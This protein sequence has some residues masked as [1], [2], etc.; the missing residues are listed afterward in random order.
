MSIDKAQEMANSKSLDLVKIAPQADPPVCR[1]MDYGKYMFEL[2][3]KDK[4]ARKKQK[5]IGTKEIRLTPSIEEHDYQFKLKNSLKFLKNGDKVKISIRFR[6]R[7]LNH[8][9]AG[10]D[11]MNRFAKDA[12]ELATVE[13]NPKLEGRN[14]TMILAPK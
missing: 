8:S 3:K 7:E 1:I 4:E 6:G 12:E 2:S 10:Y 5:V 11:I 13:K 9:S 14:M